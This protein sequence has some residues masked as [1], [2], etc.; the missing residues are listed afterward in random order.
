MESSLFFHA[1]NFTA[2]YCS[3]LASLSFGILWLGTRSRPLR[4]MPVSALLRLVGLAAALG[5]AIMEGSSARGGSVSMVVMGLSLSGLTAFDGR[6]PAT[7]WR[8]E[9]RN[10]ARDDALGLS[11]SGIV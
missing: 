10:I 11:L 1:R 7:G 8:R 6:V 3:W 4:F 9:G 2:A 5:N